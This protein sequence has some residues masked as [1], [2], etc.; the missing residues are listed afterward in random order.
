MKHSIFI[1]AIL[2]A[3]VQSAAAQQKHKLTG[4]WKGE[5][6][7]DSTLLANF[8]TSFKYEND[9]YSGMFIIQ[10]RKFPYKKIYVTKDDSVF[11]YIVKGMNGKTH[12]KGILQNDSL[13][14]GEMHQLGFSFPFKLHRFTPDTT[15]QAKQPKP[16]HHKDVIIQKNDSI[17]IGGTL[18][19]P[20]KEKA[21][22]LVIMITGSGMLNRNEAIHGISEFEPIASYLTRH[23]IA[24]YRYDDRGVGESTGNKQKATLNLLVS[25]VE[26]IINHFSRDIDHHFNKIVLLGHSQGG[27]IAGKTAAEDSLVDK[28]ILMSS[29]SIKL[30]D[31]INY[32]L[33]GNL[34]PFGMKK[35]EIQKAVNA[36]DSVLRAARN[37]KNLDKAKKHY[38]QQ[39]KKM[40]KTLP[41]SINNSQSRKFIK[42][43]G[44]GVLRMSLTPMFKSTNFY[45]P[46]NDLRKL[47]IPVLALFGGKD[48]K[49]QTGKNLQPMVSALDSAGISYQINVFKN[50]NH[51]YVLPKARNIN[52]YSQFKKNPFVK[53]FL[54]TI[55]DWLKRTSEEK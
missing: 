55:T 41:D 33:K 45:D 40:M 43:L 49:V 10:G 46:A 9:H 13:I 31:V 30:I 29:P 36:Y 26:T 4:H 38:H 2:I 23:G 16:Y 24:T 53:G 19:W 21:H 47:N 37:G 44:S 28:L 51:S 5:L 12:F 48:F 52:N 54:P 7:Q 3:L 17:R 25:D 6:Y 8:K 35:P 27:I 18:T 22:Q 32:Q 11:L 50:A 15:K 1:F 34:E 39:Y 14:I 42:L 20:K